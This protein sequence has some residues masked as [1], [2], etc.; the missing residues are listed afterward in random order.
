MARVKRKDYEKLDDV[1]VAR[2][3][4]L[5]EQDKPVTK[6]AACEILNISY[7]TARLGK[8]IQEYKDKIEY[9]KKRMKANKGRAFNEY[10]I[11]DMV[12]SYLSGESITKIAKG[13]F[14]STHVVKNYLKVIKMPVRS[15][16]ATY[17]KPDMLPDDMV[18]ETFEIGEMVWSSRYNCVAEI[19]DSEWDVT[20]QRNIYALWTFG[21]YNQFAVQPAHE[22]G[23]LEILK[24]FKL[25][26]DEFVTTQ[27][28]F[29]MRIV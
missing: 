13:L 17:H 10:E 8:I 21:K 19:R 27:Q 6:K 22:L 16:E 9:T 12:I 2:V 5:L 7:N 4:Q 23:K 24:Q 15:S 1:T 20:N 25:R 18:S 14:R 3:I 29:D 26:D 28:S 11:K